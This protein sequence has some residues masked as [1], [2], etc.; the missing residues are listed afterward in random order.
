MLNLLN[1]CLVKISSIISIYL[2][3]LLF[4]I[5]I[6]L[7]EISVKYL[8]YNKIFLFFKFLNKHFFLKI[9]IYKKFK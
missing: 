6:F 4:D 2:L 9:K 7:K 5:N 8:M 1:Y 3:F